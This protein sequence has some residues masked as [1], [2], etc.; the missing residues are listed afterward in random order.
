M[1]GDMIKFLVIYGVIL[2]TFSGVSSLLFG[3]LEEFHE[4]THVFILNFGYGL[5]NYDVS[6]FGLLGKVFVVFALLLNAITMINFVIAILA[7]TFTELQNSSLGLYYDG[8]ISRIPVYEDDSKYGGL[9]VGIPPFN[10]LAL[11]MI[12]V[13]AL[14]KNEET[15]RKVNDLFTKALFLPVCLTYTAFFI[16]VNLI[17]LPL[18]YLSAILKKVKLIGLKVDFDKVFDLFLFIIFGVP[19]LALS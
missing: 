11:P 10:L 18:A 5:A 3:D 15:L 12:P 4:F 14:I 2:L 16:A 7:Y 19:M 17:L 9:I 8:V 6:I 13:Y 1:I